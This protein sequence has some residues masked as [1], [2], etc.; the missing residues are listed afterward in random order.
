MRGRKR[1]QGGKTSKTKAQAI[2]A[3][4]RARERLGLELGDDTHRRIVGVIQ[5]S[6][7]RVVERQSHRVTV[8]DVDL[9][10]ATYR[11]VY[12]RHRKQVVTFLPP[13]E[14]VRRIHW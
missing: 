5:S 6:R 3:R 13:D 10:G 1:H 14:P 2:H 8:H 12:D 9:D 7:S 4:K 11:V